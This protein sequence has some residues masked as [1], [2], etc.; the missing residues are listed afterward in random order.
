MKTIFENA[1]LILPGH[2]TGKGD[3]LVENGRIAEIRMAGPDAA[4][5][6]AGTDA[7]RVDCTGKLLMP[8]LV[9][10]HGHTAMTLVCG[11]GGGLG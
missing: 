8:G 10:C 5:G 3:V 7:V 11:V 9:N 1:S 4:K 6:G 2:Q